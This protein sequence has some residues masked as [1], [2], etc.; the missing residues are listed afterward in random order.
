MITSITTSLLSLILPFFICV[1]MISVLRIIAQDIGLL[2]KPCPRKQHKG[3]VPLVGGIAMFVSFA[4]STLLLLPDIS[5]LYLVSITSVV[6]IL[7]VM[8]DMYGLQTRRR[9]LVQVF[10]AMSMIYFGGV[11]LLQ[12]GDL[13]WDGVVYLGAV[14]SLI[15]TIFCVVGVINAMN[16][17]DG[18]D[19]LAGGI[20]LMCFTSLSVIAYMSGEIQVLTVLLILM[21]SLAGFLLFNVQI[22]G[23]PAR[24]FMG[25][26]GSMFLGL[27]L[28]W[29]F[30]HLTQSGN[31]GLSA[32]AAGWMFG[33]PLLD[34]SAVMTRRV[35][36]GR[37]PFRAG[38]DHM[39]HIMLDKG[40]SINKT[41]TIILL[42]QLIFI[43]VGALTNKHSAW[44]PAFFW[45]FI[46][47]VAIYLG[48]THSAVS[49]VNHYCETDGQ[50]D[51]GS[52]KKVIH[53]SK[54]NA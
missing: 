9:F 21:G 38:R 37:S 14:I 33:V 51:T 22:F 11:Q 53:K 34:A 4:I 13:F 3:L 7:G 42:L 26:A 25:D 46:I 48:V 54:T 10:A 5:S 45:L 17:M 28:A 35:L 20:A 2:D 49:S 18:V 40:F 31:R 30:I 47:M 8:D 36:Q 52:A 39:H 6:V 19:G 12:L 16:M 43:G 23:Y 32:V 24:V 44:E 41:V 1:T 29:F 27:L 15:F 50:N